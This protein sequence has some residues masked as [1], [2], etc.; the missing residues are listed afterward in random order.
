MRITPNG[1]YLPLRAAPPEAAGTDQQGLYATPE[2]IFSIDDAGVV[3]P[4]SMPGPDLAVVWLDD[5]TMMTAGSGGTPAVA[6]NNSQYARFYSVFV[7]SPAVGDRW[8]FNA[9]LSRGV[10]GF[11]LLGVTFAT[12]AAE[13]DC[14]FD[15][16]LFATFDLET[17]ST[18]VN[19]TFWHEGI[20]VAQPGTY[21]VRL[22]VALSGASSS[23][24]ALTVCWF[25]KVRE[26]P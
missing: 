4:V 19:A 7:S 25:V 16:V 13:L 1:V 18:V 8:D 9:T 17:G 21:P 12:G 20:E 11:G 24:A 2:G 6:M 5:T 15:S 10:Y 3:V 23:V 22:E 26:L 14:S